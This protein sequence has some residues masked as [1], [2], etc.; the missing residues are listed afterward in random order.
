MLKIHGARLRGGVCS[1]AG[2]LSTE[3]YHLDEIAA[4][5]ILVDDGYACQLTDREGLL[6][7]D[8][9]TRAEHA[10]PARHLESARLCRRKV[11]RGCLTR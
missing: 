7:D 4:R 8:D 3:N 2:A 11:Y 9:I 1:N 10:H 5:I 6:G